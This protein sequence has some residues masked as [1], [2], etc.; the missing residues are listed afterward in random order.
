MMSSVGQFVP[1]NLENDPEE[2]TGV[3]KRSHGHG[4]SGLYVSVPGSRSPAGHFNWEKGVL[5][6]TGLGRNGLAEAQPVSSTRG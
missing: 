1:M 5:C 3:K 4:L 2:T 6:F